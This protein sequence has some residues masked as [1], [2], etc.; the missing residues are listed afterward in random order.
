MFRHDNPIHAGA[1]RFPGFPSL[2]AMMLMLL[3]A[4]AAVAERSQREGDVIVH[5]NALPT[6]VLGADVATRY[7]IVR[8]KHRGFVNIAVLRTSTTGTNS[9]ISAVI[10]ATVIS[11]IGQRQPIEL[12]EV[13]DQDAIYYIGEFTIRG[14]ELLRFDLDVKPHGSNRSIPIRFEQSFV[15]D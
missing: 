15:T 2:V 4:Q 9:A 11:L 8:S 10:K 3:S 12:R 6:T 13:R 14:E 1:A 5:Y 7:G